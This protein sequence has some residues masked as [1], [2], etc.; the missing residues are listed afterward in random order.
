[1]VKIV[2][3]WS[4]NFAEENVVFGENPLA[5]LQY[6]RRDH[7][8]RSFE[9]NLYVSKSTPLSILFNAGKPMMALTKTCP[10]RS[11]DVVSCVPSGC[12]YRVKWVTTALS[13]FDLFVAELVGT[14]KSRNKR[15]NVSASLL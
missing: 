10:P 7:K 6:V 1:M 9:Q 8:L 12:I 11:E 4:D 14:A 15:L 2:V 5:A 3:W 13:W